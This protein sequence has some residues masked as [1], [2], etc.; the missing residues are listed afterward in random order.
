MMKTTTITLCMVV[1][2]DEPSRLE[3]FHSSEHPLRYNAVADVVVVVVVAGKVQRAV[4][5][6]TASIQLP[7]AALATFTTAKLVDTGE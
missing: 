7:V 5:S 6:L 1:V 4:F 3:I 2:R